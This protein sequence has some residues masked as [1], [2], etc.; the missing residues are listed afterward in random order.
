MKDS[1]LT[2]V[3]LMTTF[4]TSRKIEASPKTI[5]EAI[6]NPARLAKWWGPNG[7]TN[8]FQTFE[9]KPK[10]KWIF[11]MHGPDGKS[12]PNESVFSLIDIDRKV[13][14]QHICQP[15]FELAITL[16]Q[17]DKG[18]LVKW[19]QT[20]SDSSVASAVKHIVVPA[21][22]QNLDRLTREVLP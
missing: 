1:F 16:I 22:E 8:T 6:Q 14:I 9:F 5:F 4:S 18:T 3:K 11:T 7:F 21:N 10:G 15:L 12:Y 17:E 20:F 19:D 13:V 2:Q